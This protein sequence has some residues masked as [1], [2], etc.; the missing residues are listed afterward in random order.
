MRSHQRA[1]VVLAWIQLSLAC[2]SR[3]QSLTALAEEFKMDRCGISRTIKRLETLGLVR[4]SM[5]S[6]RGSIWIW[7]VKK[8]KNDQPND[9]E[10]PGWHIKDLDCNT[11]HWVPMGKRYEWAAKNGIKTRAFDDFIGKRRAILCR[12]WEIISWP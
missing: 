6:K 12:K 2:P 4:Y 5:I 8:N 9:A 1:E 7:W 3:F 10:E 11:Y